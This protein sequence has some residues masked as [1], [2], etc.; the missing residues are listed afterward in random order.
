MILSGI[1]FVRPLS[2]GFG[3]EVWLA[4]IGDHP[5]VVRRFFGPALEPDA[6]IVPD[7][8]RL[9]RISHPRLQRLIWAGVDP[10]GTQVQVSDFVPG[11]SL[12]RLTG[13][14]GMTP[15]SPAGLPA[16]LADGLSA[17]KYLHED[18]HGAPL[19]HGDIS[20]A[21]AVID[22][23]G[24][25]ASMTLVDVRGAPS[26]V[27]VSQKTGVIFGTLPYLPD[28]VLAGRPPVQASD[29]WA[30]A[31]TMAT[32]FGGRVTWKSAMTP[33]A[34]LELRRGLRVDDCLP[35]PEAASAALRGLI[36]DMLAPDAADRP[37]AAQALERLNSI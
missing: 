36:G 20:P 23:T 10:E 6:G 3:V 22:G 35:P 21:N 29:V 25:D 33:N 8:A 7:A 28:E 13:D 12:R 27:P 24:A 26:G 1:R 17:L 5:V 18:C 34:V 4:G 14:H 15:P 31:M 16:M 19:L 30:L 37:T 32:G 11:N 2:F 9:F